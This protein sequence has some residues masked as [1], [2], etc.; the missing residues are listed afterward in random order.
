[1]TTK[2]KLELI[3]QVL[4]LKPGSL[5]EATELNTLREWDS[6]TILGLQV[7][8]TAINPALQFNDLF[9]CD[10]VGEICELI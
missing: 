9:R 8:L 1:M 6:F 3:E 2:E 5:T 7:R 10:T 4:R